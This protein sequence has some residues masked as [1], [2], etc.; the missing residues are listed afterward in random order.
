LRKPPFG[1]CINCTPLSVEFDGILIHYKPTENNVMPA[2]SKTPVAAGRYL[3][4]Q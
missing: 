3:N 2:S 1:A 4:V